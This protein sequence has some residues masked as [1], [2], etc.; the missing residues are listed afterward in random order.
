[1]KLKGKSIHSYYCKYFITLTFTFM[2]TACFIIA[3]NETIMYVVP[4]ASVHT[5]QLW[6]QSVHFTG[7]KLTTRFDGGPT[8]WIYFLCIKGW[9]EFKL[10]CL[11]YQ[12]L[13][14]QEPLYLTS[15]IP[16]TADTGCPQ[17]QSTSDR[18][19]NSFSDRRSF[20]VANPRVWTHCHYICSRTW[21]SHFRH[22]LKGHMFTL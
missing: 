6:W 1:M 3:C 11:V 21:T 19:Q 9:M 18:T 7:G 20:S 8:L 17:L 15:N 2:I 14:G 13:A 12:S 10:T 4:W 16:L 5:S 22:A